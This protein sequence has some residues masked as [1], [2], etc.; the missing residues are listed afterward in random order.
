MYS[1]DLGRS[2]QRAWGRVLSPRT[3]GAATGAVGLGDEGLPFVKE[4]AM[5]CFACFQ[6]GQ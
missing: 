2:G 3:L 1:Q 4:I 6:W 5:V